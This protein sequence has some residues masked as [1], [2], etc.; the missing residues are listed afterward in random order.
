MCFGKYDDVLVEGNPKKSI[1][2]DVFV[3]FWCWQKQRRTYRLWEEGKPPDFVLEFSS[4]N[5]YRKDLREKK[6]LYAEIGI[7]EY[8]LYDAERNLL[9]SPLMGFRLVD[10]GYISIQSNVDGGVAS[11]TLELELRLRGE[12]LGFYDFASDK[13]L[14]TPADA[15]TIRSQQAETELAQLREEIERLKL[16]TTSSE[17]NPQE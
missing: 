10:R 7:V 9:P 5:T 4:E 17:R 11:A 13:W 12:G 14:E 16:Q 2:P 6:E 3:A 1:S 8:F 15:A